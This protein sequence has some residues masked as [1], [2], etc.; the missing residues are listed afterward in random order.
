ME[1]QPQGRDRAG[2]SLRIMAEA[3]GGRTSSPR[4]LRGLITECNAPS[5]AA[6][7]LTSTRNTSRTALR[8]LR[9]EARV[10]VPGPR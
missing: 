10:V 5:P 9:D 7:V 3:R 4:T 2:Q 6:V 1:A 8:D